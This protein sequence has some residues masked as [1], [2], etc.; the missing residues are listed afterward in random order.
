MRNLKIV[1]GGYYYGPI[2]VKCSALDAWEAKIVKLN[3]KGQP[4]TIRNQRC[5]T[6]EGD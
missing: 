1:Q 6:E 3:S 2:N 5:N 4:V